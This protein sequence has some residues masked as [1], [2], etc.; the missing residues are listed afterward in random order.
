DRAQIFENIKNTPREDINAM[1]DVLNDIEKIFVDIEEGFNKNNYKNESFPIKKEEI[2]TFLLNATL[3]ITNS[4]LDSVEKQ[5]QIESLVVKQFATKPLNIFEMIL[6]AIKNLFE[7]L[8]FKTTKFSS[9]S[10]FSSSK[11]T[12][13]LDEK[14]QRGDGEVNT[15]DTVEQGRVIINKFKD[16]KVKIQDVVEEKVTLKK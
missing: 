13:G 5:Q 9:E 8:F 6:N 2:K 3:I 16:V 11:D 7:R 12:V 4:K 15:E 14:K 10:E 1:A